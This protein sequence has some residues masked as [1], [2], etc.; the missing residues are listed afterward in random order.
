ML[1]SSISFLSYDDTW[2]CITK[3]SVSHS[4]FFHFYSFIL[5]TFVV[6][7]KNKQRQRFSVSVYNIE[8]K[9]VCM[10]SYSFIIIYML[11]SFYITAGHVLVIS[12]QILFLLHRLLELKIKRN[13]LFEKKIGWE[14]KL[15]NMPIDSVKWNQEN[16]K[17]KYLC[18]CKAIFLKISLSIN[19][20]ILFPS[21]SIF[22]IY[23]LHIE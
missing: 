20:H 5:F 8:K 1:F 9:V 15:Q 16:E 10:K 23:T 12:E 4:N 7:V 14:I 11:I 21:L 13:K 3:Q 22:C 2:Q 18:L 17:I 6:A 19:F